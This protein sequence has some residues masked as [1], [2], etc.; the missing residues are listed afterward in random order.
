MPDITSTVAQGLVSPP[1]DFLTEYEVTS[2]AITGRHTYTGVVLYG[3]TFEVT[4][5]PLGYGYKLGAENEYY[6][7]LISWSITYYGRVFAMG[8]VTV[9]R[10]QEWPIS[11]APITGASH[12][13]LTV[14]Q[15]P[16]VHGRIYRLAL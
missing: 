5:I 10:W 15:A 8:N 7:P 12:Q 13:V 9:R 3:L 16:G 14:Q 1:L 4:E 2:G 6:E 11:G